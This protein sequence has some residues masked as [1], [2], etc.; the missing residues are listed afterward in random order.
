[1]DDIVMQAMR[2]WPNVPACHGWLALDGRGQWWMRDQ[3]AQQAGCFQE[4]IHTQDNVVAKGSLLTHDKLTAFIA[5]NY[6]CDAQGQWFFQNGPQ[7]VYVELAYTPWIFRVNDC[8]ESVQTHTGRNTTVTQAI[9]DERGH[10]YLLTPLGLGLVH[11]QD[12]VTAEQHLEK[13]WPL[14]ELSSLELPDRFNFV[15]SPATR[16]DNRHASP[17]LPPNTFK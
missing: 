14:S 4:A 11:T 1:M 10:L 7:R 9:C 16:H 12:V 17:P 2:K 3:H 6:T 5:R 8:A 15:V 13:E